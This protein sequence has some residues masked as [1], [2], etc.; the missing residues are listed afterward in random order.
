DYDI[1]HFRDAWS[2]VPVIDIARRHPIAT[3]YDVA[4]SP[5]AEPLLLSPEEGLRMRHD[6]DACLAAADL[7]LAP[8]E[9][10]RAY[11]EAQL[12]MDKVRIVPPGVD[13][14]AFDWEPISAR[15]TPVILYFG[16]LQ[17]GRAIRVLL[18]AFRE[19]LSRMPAALLLAG[20]STTDFLA[21]AF[22]TVAEM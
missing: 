19:V 13:V 18:H 16:S 15:G 3:V 5:L 20:R 4:R 8:H 12:Q 11:L 2:G 1:V 9:P 7:V 6:H 10:A 22:A 21:Q 14:N 17:E